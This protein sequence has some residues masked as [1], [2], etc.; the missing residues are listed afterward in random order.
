MKMKVCKQLNYR[1]AAARYGLDYSEKLI[2]D[3]QVRGRN[4]S[5]VER[6]WHRDAKWHGGKF[7][8]YL[9]VDLSEY[10]NNY[11]RL[12]HTKTYDELA[13]LLAVS[14]PV[15]GLVRF[16]VHNQSPGLWENGFNPNIWLDGRIQTYADEESR[17]RAVV[18][19]GFDPEDPRFFLA[20]ANEV[21]D[22]TRPFV[23]E[24]A[25]IGPAGTP[26]VHWWGNEEPPPPREPK[27]LEG[28]GII[29]A[30]ESP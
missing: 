19:T 23:D 8:Y 21:I 28:Y 4:W 16:G 3:G 2:F 11:D 6:T 20:V 30:E 10:Y 24:L 5:L 27:P 14:L 9:R 26:Y 18:S 22:Q 12:I 13:P 17:L 1:S 15:I 7:Q 29:E 25:A